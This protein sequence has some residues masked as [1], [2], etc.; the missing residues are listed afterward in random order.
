MAWQITMHTRG[1]K[2][3][4]KIKL[5]SKKR[6]EEKTGGGREKEMQT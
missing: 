2:L 4:V 3:T 6:L 1:Q 5:S